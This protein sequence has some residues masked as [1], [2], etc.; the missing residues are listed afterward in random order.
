MKRIQRFDSSCLLAQPPA[1]LPAWQTKVHTARDSL[2]DLNLEECVIWVFM[3]PPEVLP[4][5]VALHSVE[6]AIIPVL[7]LKIYPVG[8]I[9]I[10]VPLM[11]VTGVS[12]VVAP[13]LVISVVSSRYDRSDEGGAQE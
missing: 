5:L 9:F 12:I 1:P 2:S 13:V 8:P 7:L 4:L 3:A 10:A 6:I 11:I